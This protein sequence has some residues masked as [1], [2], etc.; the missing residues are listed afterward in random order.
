MTPKILT[1]IILIAGM[2]GT[3]EA[4]PYPDKA[5]VCATFKNNE[6]VSRDLCLIGVWT[7]LGGRGAYVKTFDKVY[8]IKELDDTKGVPTLTVNKAK[9]KRYYRH[10]GFFNIITEDEAEQL[11]ESEEGG[12]LLCY[13]SSTTDICHSE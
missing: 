13:K 10:S 1:A 12:L 11:S 4:R 5:G 8:D 2:V 6:L 3:A 9:A 7:A